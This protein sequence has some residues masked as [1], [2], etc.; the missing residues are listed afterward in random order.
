MNVQRISKLLENKN[1]L[2]IN[3]VVLNQAQ[4]KSQIVYGARA[5]NYQSPT[6]LKKKTY[7]YDI[8]S[9]SPKKSAKET[10]EILKRRLK[11]EVTVSKG[12]HRGTYRVKVN[13]EVVADYTQLK[14]APKTKKVWGTE[15]RHL[16][17][18][19]RNATRL[20]RKKGLEYRREKDLDTLEKIKKIEKMENIFNKL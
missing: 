3:E 16:K 8:L 4:K 2:V 14:K 10:A 15:V 9:K 7:D 20:S 11:K 5:Y 6:H 12:S 18:I 17:S 19:K 13:G 1:D